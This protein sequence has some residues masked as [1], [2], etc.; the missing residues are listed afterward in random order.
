[1]NPNTLLV[2]LHTEKWTP[3]TYRY[4][5]FSKGSNSILIIIP[6]CQ[7]FV[8]YLTSQN[9]PQHPMIILPS[10]PR[11]S[12]GVQSIFITT[13]MMAIVMAIPMWL[14]YILSIHNYRGYS[15]SH[16][17]L[18][19]WS[20]YNISHLRLSISHHACHRVGCLV[21]HWI[22]EVKSIQYFTLKTSHV[23]ISHHASHR[24]GCL[25][26]DW[27]SEVKIQYFT[28]K[29]SHVTISHHA[30]HR[31]G[32]LVSHWISEVK[33]IQYFTLKTSHVTIS[34]HASHRVGCLVSHWISE[35]H[36]HTIFYS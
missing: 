13:P 34:H 23:T 29:T 22:S 31:V 36:V 15:I 16:L 7:L 35:V 12:K 14:L 28:L 9:E 33:S 10:M 5:F 1:M 27:I 3:N 25:V 32:C 4:L 19:Q 6:D 18:D 26:S 24:V 11:Y 2:L 8:Y 21:S 17:R 30:G 20:M